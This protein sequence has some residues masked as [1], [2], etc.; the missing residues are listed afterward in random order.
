MAQIKKVKTGDR[1]MLGEAYL[2]GTIDLVNNAIPKQTK[3]ASGNTKGNIILV[4]NTTGD[5]VEANY[6]LSVGDILQQDGDD[7][8]PTGMVPDFRANKGIIF[9]GDTPA[10]TAGT[11]YE[12]E[13]HWCVLKNT[14]RDDEI[15]EAYIFGICPARINVSTTLDNAAN[16]Q[17]VEVANGTTILEANWRGS[18]RILWKE[19]G[20]GNVWALVRIGNSVAEV[21]DG[22]LRC[23]NNSGVIIPA[24]SIAEIEGP[25]EVL[26]VEQLGWYD[27]KK[28]SANNLFQVVIVPEVIA[29]GASGDCFFPGD[30]DKRAWA[31]TDIAVSIEDDIGS[32]A[33]SW[34]WKKDRLGHRVT[35]PY[36]TGA[37]A[38]PFRSA[39]LKPQSTAWTVSSISDYERQTSSGGGAGDDWTF[40][41]TAMTIDAAVDLRSWGHLSIGLCYARARVTASDLSGDI[42]PPG[43]RIIRLRIN[44]YD[45]SDNLLFGGDSQSGS[46]LRL[47]QANEYGRPIM[48]A[49]VREITLDEFLP[50]SGLGIGAQV[51]IP[52]M[53]A[54]PAYITWTL[55]VQTGLMND[56]DYIDLYISTDGQSCR[57]E[58]FQY[59][60]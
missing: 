40:E 7:E 30:I 4:K 16:F 59:L 58:A 12:G 60:L 3:P 46:Y 10:V 6:A 45:V 25:H 54:R 48:D 31:E 5:T 21:T 33:D 18:A 27:V 44:F 53:T 35:S 56:D 26:S 32:D 11:E 34:E 29:I 51:N 24:N 19:A 15:G 57:Y 52:S 37:Y 23:Y 47:A 17:F 2:N 22:Q 41:S 55:D 14:L 13:A 38:R 39:S 43:V 20:T 42:Y 9:L 50:I 1:V 49:S 28:P 36:G 8:L